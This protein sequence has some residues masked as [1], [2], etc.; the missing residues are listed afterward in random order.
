[1][2]AV[3]VEAQ[4]LRD[5]VARWKRLAP[6]LDEIR[7]QSLASIITSDAVRQLSPAFDLAT[8]LPA[9]ES[10]GLVEQQIIFKKLHRR[11]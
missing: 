10:S 8:K 6:E 1:M 7:L 5:H 2:V 4:L 3:N 9:R 11:P